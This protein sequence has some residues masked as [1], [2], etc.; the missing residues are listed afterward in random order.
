MAVDLKYAGAL[1]DGSELSTHSNSRILGIRLRKFSLWHR[2]LLRT[3]Q[4]PF[5]GGKDATVTLFDLATAAGICS[6]PYGNSKVR[7]P[8]LAP[9]IMQIKAILLTIWRWKTRKEENQFKRLFRKEVDTFL[10]YC[11]DYLQ[12]PDFAIIPFEGDRKRPHTPRGK[13]PPEI[14][15][16]ADIVGWSKCSFEDAWNMPVGLS[17]WYRVIAIREAGTD[18]DFVTER[19]RKFQEK[20]PKDF[21]FK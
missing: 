11:S 2:L 17:N 3:V 12:E 19:E 6:L 4:S 9:L 14:E 8:W 21:R 16:V 20:L 13:A 7:R 15:Q 5:L 10:E 1:I 18:V